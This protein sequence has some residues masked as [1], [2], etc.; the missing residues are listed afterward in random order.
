MR[1]VA[2]YYYMWC[3]VSGDIN[4]CVVWRD[5]MCG[6]LKY[7]YVWC[8][9]DSR[10]IYTCADAG[11][12][13]VWCGIVAKTLE[14]STCVLKRVVEVALHWSIY[15][16]QERER[17]H[18]RACREKRTCSLGVCERD[19]CVCECVCVFVCVCARV[20]LW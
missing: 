9:I 10:D 12:Q 2:G 17:E 20:S 19:V 1:A 4:I 6:V 11:Y 15:I 3:C 8:G 13:Y 7:Q 14:I 16:G 18:T 5:I